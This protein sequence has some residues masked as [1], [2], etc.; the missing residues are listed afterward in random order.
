LGFAVS[1]W[2]NASYCLGVRGRSPHSL[3]ANNFPWQLSPS[4]RSLPRVFRALLHLRTF[5]R[6]LLVGELVLGSQALHDTFAGDRM[7]RRRVGT[8]ARAVVVGTG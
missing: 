7:A 6:L 8:A 3:G 5:R 2:L 4:V 1:I